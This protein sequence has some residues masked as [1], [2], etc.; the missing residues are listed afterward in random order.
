M[1]PAVE[2]EPSEP[3]LDP[4]NLSAVWRQAITACGAR[5][6]V[7]RREDVMHDAGSSVVR[8]VL[9]FMNLERIG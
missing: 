8:K 6:L 3:W 1:P 5:S 2:S 9:R 7:Q 4:P